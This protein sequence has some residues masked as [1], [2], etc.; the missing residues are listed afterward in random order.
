M[1]I[2]VKETNKL[3]EINIFDANGSNWTGDLVGYDIN[4]TYNIDTEEYECTQETYD[5]WVDHI[6]RRQAADDRWE[7][8][9]DTADSDKYDKMVE[10]VANAFNCDMTDYPEVLDNLCD[11]YD[12]EVE[13]NDK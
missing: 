12:T 9:L 13:S 7:Q 3:E 2:R 6:E 1:E 11:V 5:W 4:I 8:L 10:D